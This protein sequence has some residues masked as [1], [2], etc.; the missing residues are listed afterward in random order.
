MTE[1]LLDGSYWALSS[2]RRQPKKV[3]TLTYKEDH[4]PVHKLSAP[5]QLTEEQKEKQRIRQKERNELRKSLE[6]S[7]VEEETRR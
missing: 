3:D 1:S 6:K 7:K 5:V 4:I 2:G